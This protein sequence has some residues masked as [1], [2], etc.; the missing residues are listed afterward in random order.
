ME[1]Y[2]NIDIGNYAPNELPPQ[3]S[4][5]FDQIESY[6][7]IIK[8]LTDTEKL[9]DNYELSL[10][11]KKKDENGKIVKDK[12]LTPIIYNDQTAKEFV[13]MIRCVANQNTHFSDFEEKDIYN[14][15]NAMNYTMNRWMMFQGTKIPI[16]HRQKLSFEAMNIAK[17][18]LHKAKKFRILQWSKGQITHSEGQNYG[19]KQ[20][21][22][23]MDFVFP[24]KTR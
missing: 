14:A 22:G 10:T 16:R 2:Q 13:D 1:E 6:G 24:N 9:L 23:F 11:G 4:K 21:K 15:L 17:A 20:K 18:S 3:Y 12:K 8:E 19:N 5:D 7:S